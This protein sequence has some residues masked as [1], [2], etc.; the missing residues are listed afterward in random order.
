MYEKERKESHEKRKMRDRRREKGPESEKFSKVSV[1]L[2][3]L[4]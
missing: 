3:S 2:N 1:L 4:C